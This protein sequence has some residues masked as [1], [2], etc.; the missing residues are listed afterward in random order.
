MSLAVAKASSD[1]QPVARRAIMPRKPS[2]NSGTIGAF[3]PPPPTAACCRRRHTPT[4]AT[5]GASRMTRVSLTSSAGASDASAY[6][7]AV[8]VTWPTSWTPAPAHAPN[9]MAGRSMA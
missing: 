6:A 9:W 7:D 8:A 5:S 4:P 2:T 3:L 1:S